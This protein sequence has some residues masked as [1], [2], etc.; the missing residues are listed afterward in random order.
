MSSRKTIAVAFALVTLNVAPAR[1]QAVAVFG[2][3]EAAGDN[4]TLALLG[5][6][7]SPGHI[8]WQ[9]YVSA[10]G[11]NL[12][13]DNGPISITRNVF[14]PQAGLR[15]QNAVS[16]VQIGAGYS[17][18]SGD[19]GVFNVGAQTAEGAFGAFQWNHWG[20]GNRSL[21]AIAS[22]GT[23][24]EFFWSRFTG[25][26]RLAPASPLF[27]GA[28]VGAYGSTKTNSFWT[29]QLGPAVEWRFTPTFRLGAAA[30]LKVGLSSPPGATR[31]SVAYGRISFLWLPA[32][33]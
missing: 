26:Q 12:R 1:A 2:A 31:K 10:I 11:Y 3:A 24:E 9:P 21:E 25:L 8:G 33:K 22:Y 17:F 32:F 23:K 18:A 29:G 5:A 6:A 30:G 14:A 19:A 27:V 16:A 7:W 4:Q 20:T 15:Y 28:E 13:F